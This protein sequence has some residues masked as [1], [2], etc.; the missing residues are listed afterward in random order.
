MLICP[1]DACLRKWKIRG[2]GSWQGYR[3]VVEP[4]YVD[5]R[6]VSAAVFEEDVWCA[7]CSQREHSKNPPSRWLDNLCN[8][9][10]CKS[11]ECLLPE[12]A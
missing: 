7:R 6:E 2:A 11:H 1:E 9:C 8:W 12:E 3:Q 10:K 5:G 4:Q